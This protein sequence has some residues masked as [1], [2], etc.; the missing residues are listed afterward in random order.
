MIDINDVLEAYKVD[1]F[2]ILSAALKQY[3]KKAN[4]RLL[5]LE[6]AGYDYYAYDV[7]T[8]Y[9]MD[10][11]GTNRYSARIKGRDKH[12]IREEILSIYQFLNNKTS[13]V[14]GQKELERSRIERF[15]EKGVI[16][17]DMP[18][19]KQ[20]EFLRFLGSDSVR[21]FVDA[22]GNSDI[23]VDTLGNAFSEDVEIEFLDKIVD[24]FFNNEISYL[25]YM[26]IIGELKNA[27]SDCERR[28]I[29]R[30]W[31]M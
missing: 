29:V 14:K 31:D 4:S 13:T 9:T 8:S 26:D 25:D 3:A 19:D 30:K 10:V 22:I 2:N 28:A 18:R 27:K 23:V 24:T 11:F 1:D 15:V 5:R 12:D 6:K 17:E 20:V 7:A 16:S 21:N